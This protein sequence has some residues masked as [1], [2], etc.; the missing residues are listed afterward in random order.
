MA[1]SITVGT[2][3]VC[4]LPPRP[5]LRPLAE[6]T[7]H[8]C[9]RLERASIDVLN[10]Q[11]VWFHGSLRDL[12]HG[13]PSYPYIAYRQGLVGPAGGLVT[14]SRLPISTV[15][16]RPFLAIR[17]APGGRRWLGPRRFALSAVKGVLTVGL[18][19]QPVTVVSA[20]LTANRDDDYTVGNRFYD[21]QAEQLARLDAHLG[22][23][24]H[25]GLTVVTGDV[26]APSTCS[27]YPLVTGQGRRRDPFA[28]TDPYTYHPA[29]LHRGGVP[30]R[31]D[32]LLLEGDPRR[33]PVIEAAT[34][35]DRPIQLG[36]ETEFYLS[37]HVGL[38][39]TVALP[40]I[41]SGAA[42]G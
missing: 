37:D 6:R 17:P 5:P 1:A 25:D 22:R 24:R 4:G 40:T 8:L 14:F 29:F 28:S 10:L 3:N 31:V 30:Y 21:F 12:R 38:T 7:P 33:Y 23:L 27:L 32:Y 35:F 42:D 19:D 11:E 41:R 26:N 15:S 13:L 18:K 2:L 20:H 34:L 9:S 16:Y 36:A 39:V